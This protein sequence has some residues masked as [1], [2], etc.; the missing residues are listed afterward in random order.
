MC[1]N[2]RDQVYR[3][4]RSDSHLDQRDIRRAP[5]VDSSAVIMEVTLADLNF[6]VALSRRAPAGTRN[7]RGSAPEAAAHRGS[8]IAEFG[9]AGLRWCHLEC[10][11]IV[12][13][14]LRA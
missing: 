12:G 1:F 14:I 6:D 8:P 3:H 2:Q 5:R 4:G 10:E 13:P 7:G 9:H 11:T